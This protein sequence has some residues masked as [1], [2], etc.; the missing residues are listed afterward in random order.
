M[1]VNVQAIIINKGKA[2]LNRLYKNRIEIICRNQQNGRGRRTR[3]LAERYSWSFMHSC[4]MCVLVEF[5]KKKIKSLP[6]LGEG[7]LN[8]NS[9]SKNESVTSHTYAKLPHRLY[10]TLS[11]LT[12]VLCI[13]KANNVLTACTFYLATQKRSE[14]LSFY[15]TLNKHPIVNECRKLK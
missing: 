8:I 14:S 10:F 1:Y 11:P 12:V 2:V 9:S 7:K 4:R 5:I 15:V 3:S 6:A 13:P